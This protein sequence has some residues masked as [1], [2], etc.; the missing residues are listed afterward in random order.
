VPKQSTFTA[1][2]VGAIALFGIAW[3]AST[4]V[5]AN[6]ADITSTLGHVVDDHK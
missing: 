2:M 1:G 6:K 5:D 4:F 3:L